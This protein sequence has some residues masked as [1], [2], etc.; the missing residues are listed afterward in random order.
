MRPRTER[1]KEF[2]NG[3]IFVGIH[4]DKEIFLR[5]DEKVKTNGLTKEKYVRE[6]ILKD[7]GLKFIPGHYQ[8]IE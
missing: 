5:M 3:D 2:R 6:L 7:L 8:Q 1:V 4:L